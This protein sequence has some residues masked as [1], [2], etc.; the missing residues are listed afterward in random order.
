MFKFKVVTNCYIRIQHKFLSIHI[1]LNCTVDVP[2]PPERVVT[3]MSPR[4]LQGPDLATIL[5]LLFHSADRRQSQPQILRPGDKRNK[6]LRPLNFIISLEL[7]AFRLHSWDQLVYI[8][9]P[10]R[11]T[12][13]V[14]RNSPRIVTLVPGGPSFGEIPVTT[15]GGPIFSNCDTAPL[16]EQ[17]VFCTMSDRIYSLTERKYWW[18]VR[19]KWNNF[20][21]MNLKDKQK[22]KRQSKMKVIAILCCLV[23]VCQCQKFQCQIVQCQCSFSR[24]R[25]RV[26][27]TPLLVVGGIGPNV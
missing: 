4:P 27:P 26:Q 7:E 2:S 8:G 24:D 11:S 18:K 9:L 12:A 10:T 13:L 22:T 17:Q 25:V 21:W 6:S 16:A 19:E 14:P 15:G 5:F 3:I 23:F 20:W 1:P